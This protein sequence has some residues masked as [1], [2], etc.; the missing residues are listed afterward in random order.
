MEPANVGHANIK[1]MLITM[2]TIAALDCRLRRDEKSQQSCQVED[3]VISPRMYIAMKVA[4]V[5][6]EVAIEVAT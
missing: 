5:M 6:G 4:Y 1:S 3:A 2:K